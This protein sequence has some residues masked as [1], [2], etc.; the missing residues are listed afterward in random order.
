M[1]LNLKK[2]IYQYKFLKLEL[3]DKKEEHSN[4]SNEF[5][6]LFSDIIKGKDS[7]KSENK[8]NVEEIT[9][10]ILDKN[11]QSKIDGAT[12]KIYKDVAKKLHPDKGGDGDVFKELSNRYKSNDLLGVVD[13]AIE[14]DVEFTISD[15]DET[16]L[17]E[18]INQ[19]NRK[20]EHYKTTLAYVWKHGN[21]QQRQSVLQTL[22]IHLEKKI[23]IESLNDEIKSMLK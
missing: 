5:E 8:S 14:N 20:I 3:D 13:L 2:L 23:D 19:L 9:K 11:S 4:L 16:Q 21:Q 1:M 17:F 7:P 22:S 12:K 10:P 18:S 15:E 6:T